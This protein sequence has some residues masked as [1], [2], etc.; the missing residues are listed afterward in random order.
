MTLILLYSDHR[1]VSAIDVA[2]FSVV[3]ARTQI[4]SH[5]G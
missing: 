2:I 1:H 5:R 3:S 4:H